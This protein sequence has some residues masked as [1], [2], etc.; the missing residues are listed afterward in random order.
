MCFSFVEA[1]SLSICLISTWLSMD[2]VIGITG[3]A[4]ISFSVFFKPSIYIPASDSATN[5][6]SRV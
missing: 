1:A 2:I 3:G 6:D 4:L 5:S